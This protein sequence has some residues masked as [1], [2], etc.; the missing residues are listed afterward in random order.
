[1]TI[2]RDERQVKFDVEEREIMFSRQQPIREMTQM[3]SQP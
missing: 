1:M 3:L 2:M